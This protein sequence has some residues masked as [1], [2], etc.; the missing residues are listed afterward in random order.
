MRYKLS[1]IAKSFRT[2]RLMGFVILYVTNQFVGKTQKTL[3]SQPIAITYL[4][5]TDH[6]CGRRPGGYRSQPGGRGAPY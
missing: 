4:V 2:L 1:V 6:E 3:K 5:S